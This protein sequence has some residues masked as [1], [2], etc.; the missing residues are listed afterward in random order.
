MK[1]IM[2]SW[3]RFWQFNFISNFSFTTQNLEWSNISWGQLSFD[4]EPLHSTMW[5]H[6][7]ISSITNF[8]G[9]FSTLRIC[10][11]FLSGLCY[12]Q[13]VLNQLDFLFGFFDKF[14]SE[15]T[16]FSHTIPY[17][18]GGTFYPIE[19]LKWCHLNAGLIAVVI[20]KFCV[21]Q[22]FIPTG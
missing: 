6:S 7:K 10:V 11:A 21:R 18:W 12:L 20:R 14:W 9:D 1:H 4:S 3:Q 22:T 15:Q 2:D 8:V 19:K 17:Q 5:R 16:S 13:S